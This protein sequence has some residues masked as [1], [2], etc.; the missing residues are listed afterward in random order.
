MGGSDKLRTTYSTFS[1]MVERTAFSRIKGKLS[2]SRKINL[3]S[4]SDGHIKP[5]YPPAFRSNRPLCIISVLD[6][7]F[8]YGPVHKISVLI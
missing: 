2:N 5:G 6:F 1:R 3:K 7:E 8:W 4:S